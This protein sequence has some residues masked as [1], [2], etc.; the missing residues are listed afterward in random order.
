SS[1]IRRQ[2][3]ETA[4]EASSCKI[5]RA[6]PTRT[7]PRPSDK[8]DGE[9]KMGKNIAVV[10]SFLIEL[11]IRNSVGKELVVRVD[12]G[13]LVAELLAIETGHIFKGPVS[14]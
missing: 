1:S 11:M 13:P 5:D 12:G 6:R 7:R 8:D 14:F 2:P 9:K 4:R 3:E 10:I